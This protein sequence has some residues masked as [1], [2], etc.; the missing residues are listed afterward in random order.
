M[1]KYDVWDRLKCE[2]DTCT[3]VRRCAFYEDCFLVNARRKAA[4]VD[5]LIVNH[6][7]LFAD[8]SLR[9]NLGSLADV[10]VLP[11]YNRVIIDEAHHIEEASTNYFGRQISEF[12]I[13]RLF[14]RLV[15]RAKKGDHKGLLFT[16]LKKVRTAQSKSQQQRIRQVLS[17]I[18]DDLITDIN[19]LTATG[20]DIFFDVGAF[21][22]QIDTMSYGES[23]FMLDERFH[24]IPDW[25]DLLLAK[26][27]GLMAGMRTLKNKLAELAQ[28]LDILSELLSVDLDNLLIELQAQ[29]HR[30][31]NAAES[32]Q[33]L[34]F[35]EDPSI[36]EWIERSGKQKT[37]TRY[38]LHR[39][40]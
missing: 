28:S 3:G 14:G 25:T 38:V 40:R 34:L 21:I 12:G 31:G 20:E 2:S 35:E 1:P 17:F 19:E 8:L 33:Y 5:I 15:S 30:I 4:Q 39:S 16:V 13:K 37:I 7:L 6:H 24:D 9:G 23:Q 11:L 36:V 22:E 27:K 29:A 10:A 18:K 32:I 26:F